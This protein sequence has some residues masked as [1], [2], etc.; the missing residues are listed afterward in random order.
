M[1]KSVAEYKKSF[2]ALI[3]KYKTLLDNEDFLG[4]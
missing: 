2:Q 1:R 3:E 4:E